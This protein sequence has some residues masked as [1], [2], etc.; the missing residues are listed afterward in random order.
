MSADGNNHAAKTDVET[1]WLVT[2]VCLNNINAGFTQKHEMMRKLKG[3][4]FIFLMWQVGLSA[5]QT[6]VCNQS[7]NNVGC[8]ANK[9]VP[10]L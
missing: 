4:L 2:H 6:A 1:R 5:L 10:L 7:W 9:S 8:T 3:I